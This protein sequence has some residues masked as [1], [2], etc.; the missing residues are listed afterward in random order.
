MEKKE[1]TGMCRWPPEFR[2]LLTGE[3]GGDVSVRESSGC[4][5]GELVAFREECAK[6]RLD[7][8]GSHQTRLASL[9]DVPQES[10]Q[11]EGRDA[12]SGPGP[13]TTVRS[14]QFPVTL[15]FGAFALSVHAL[16]ELAAYAIGFALLRRGQRRHGDVV[17]ADARWSLNVA[18]ILGAAV[19]SKLVHVA[20]DP[21]A[22]VAHATEPMFWLGGKSMVGGLI[23]GAAAV[24]FMKA[25]MGITRR[26]GAGLVL[27]LIAGIAVGRVG[28]FLSGLDDQT[29][30]TATSLPWGVDFGDGI[31]RHPTQLY[32]IAFLALLG[33]ALARPRPRTTAHTHD[34][35]HTHEPAHTHEP[36]HAHTHAGW[37]AG[38]EGWRFDAFFFAYLGFR[39]GVDFLKPY[40]HLAA[41]VGGGLAATQ[42]A[43]LLGIVARCAWLARTPRSAASIA[44]VA[45]RGA[46]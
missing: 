30:G 43:C 26:T 36:T 11:R 39:F 9:R 10:P 46:S 5:G 45:Q 23:G 18:A 6:G 16:L 12:L 7:V 28:C 17:G 42:W 25:R 35:T 38:R 13:A 40:E 29:F 21:A 8:A 1:A 24:E 32:E 44:P 19:G 34:P 33:L 14:V 27:P 41:P 15:Q 22:L 3:G 4:A 2:G 31:A 37:L 20:G